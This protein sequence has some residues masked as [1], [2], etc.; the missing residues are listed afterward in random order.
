MHCLSSIRRKIIELVPKL[1]NHF[2]ELDFEIIIKLL[3]KVVMK[4]IDRETK[5]GFGIGSITKIWRKIV[6]SQGIKK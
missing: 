1:E 4:L 3:K 2:F 6:K 5:M